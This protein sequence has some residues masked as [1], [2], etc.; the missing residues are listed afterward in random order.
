[1]LEGRGILQYTNTVKMVVDSRVKSYFKNVKQVFLYIID[2]CNLDC[3]QCLYK[4]NNYF[5]IGQKYIKLDTAKKLILFFYNLGAKKL[6]IMG[7]EPT[8]Y[9]KEEKHVPLLNLIEYAK[10]IGY[11]Y[12]RIDTNGTFEKELLYESQFKL[13]DEITFSLDGPNAKIND[14][15]RGNGVFD[16]CVSNIELARNLNYRCDITCCI[17][18]DLI[19]R[20]ID[21]QLYLDKMILFAEKLKI[22]RINFHDLF[23][24]GIPRDTWT[25]KI[26]I[27]I[28][29]WFN[30]WNE[31]QDNINS[32]RYQIPIRIPQGF[33]SKERFHI[34][35]EYYGY[36]S[37]KIGD[38]VLLHPDGIFRVCSLMIGTPYGLGRFYDDK[39]VWDD[40][41]TNE[42][43]SHNMD[44]L[45]PCTNQIKANIYEP[46]LPVCVSFKPKQ[47]EFVWN[48]LE[49]EKNKE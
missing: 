24:S 33:V 31:I 30:V 6:T 36:C 11:E 41:G 2:E 26:N 22:H 5:H 49:W 42:L 8:L 13:L 32:G 25:G 14:K 4:P 47:D 9:G 17:H 19:S 16:K 44:E 43:V 45:T 28:E 35:K 10:E 12:V 15:I 39:I 1:M 40:S 27:S 21:N 38:R 29:E 34:N 46:F 20:D 3:V 23:K 7:G 37:A 48:L 18:R